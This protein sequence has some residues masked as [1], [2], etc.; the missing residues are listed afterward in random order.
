MCASVGH[1]LSSPLL[2]FNFVNE[3]MDHLRGSSFG[4]SIDDVY[5]G[6]PIY[7]DRLTLI[8]ASEKDKLDI[9]SLHAS[10]WCYKINAQK[11]SILVFGESP[12]C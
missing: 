6:A 2:Y 9:V 11:S 12:T 7:A 4:V 8:S 10:C 5:C 1:S 3:L